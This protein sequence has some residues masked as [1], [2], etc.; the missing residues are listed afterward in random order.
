MKV[1]IDT[2]ILISA[3]LKGGKPKIAIASVIASSR[4]EWIASDAIIREYKEVLK[5]PKLK[6]SES[7]KSEF[8]EVIDLAVI[9]IDVNITVD[10]TRDRKDAKFLACALAS[11]ADY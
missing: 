7:S 4:F 1:I 5:R 3:A 9:P 10:F 2:N 6:L 8:L 11:N